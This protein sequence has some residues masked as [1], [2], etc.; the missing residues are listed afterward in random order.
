MNQQNLIAQPLEIELTDCESVLQILW[1]DGHVGRHRLDVIRALSPLPEIIDS[2]PPISVELAPRTYASL[3]IVD[4]E[5]V[6]R[7]AFGFI[8]SDGLETGPYDFQFLRD[9]ENTA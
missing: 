5:V 6:G 7:Q 8:W 4:V 2:C 1:D 9:I 3:K